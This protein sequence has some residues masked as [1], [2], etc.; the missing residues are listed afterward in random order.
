MR[1]APRQ[2]VVPRARL[3][4]LSFQ[5][6]FLRSWCGQCTVFE[7]RPSRTRT[8]NVICKTSSH[9]VLLLLDGYIY[10]RAPTFGSEPLGV[11]TRTTTT[12][13]WDDG[14]ASG[15]VRRPFFPRDTEARSKYLRIPSCVRS[16][17]CSRCFS[18][19]S[20]SLVIIISTSFALLQLLLC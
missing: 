1:F 16:A 7:P 8:P 9:P 15:R 19:F 4:T 20:E 12:R 10:I 6:R 14:D 3:R 17:E 5:A 18:F 13:P 2:D 11:R